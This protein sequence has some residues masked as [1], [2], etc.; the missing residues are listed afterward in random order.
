MRHEIRAAMQAHVAANR[1]G[2]RYV[3]YDAVEDKLLRLDFKELHRGIAQ[4]GDFYVSCA[5][6]VDEAGALYDLDFLVAPVGGQ[7]R[8]LQ[9]V[10]HSVGGDERRYHVED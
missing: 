10:V 5:D 6:F 9:A 4:K 1:P 8:V 3:V 7:Y 2:D